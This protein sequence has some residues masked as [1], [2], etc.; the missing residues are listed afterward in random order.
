MWSGPRNLS[1]AMMRAFANRPDCAAVDEPFYAAYLHATGVVH[2]MQ[3]EILASQ[4]TDPA[5]VAEALADRAVA[6]AA[7]A[8]LQYEKH[9]THHMVDAVPRHWFADADHVFLIRAPAR[10]VASYAA[11]RDTVTLADLGFEQQRVLFDEITEQRGIRPSVIDADNVLADPRRTL[12]ALC[13]ALDIA[14]DEAMLTWPAG[15][16]PCDGV[17]ATHWYGQVERS[18]G[19]GAARPKPALDNPAHR[20]LAAAAEPAYA[21]LAAHAV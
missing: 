21:H 6:S 8:A 16:W 13:D 19:F 11:K 5:V 3:E 2:P 4:P 20:A 10:V 12:S 17:W 1:T 15:R 18:T 14:F 9:M 7:S